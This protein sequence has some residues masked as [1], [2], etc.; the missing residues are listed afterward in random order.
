VALEVEVMV[1]ELQAALTWVAV[2]VAEITVVHLA[3]AKVDQVYSLLVILTHL[4]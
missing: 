3:Q 2:V 4:L 1:L